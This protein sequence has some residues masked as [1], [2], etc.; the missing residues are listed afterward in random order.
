M[1]LIFERNDG[2]HIELTR[3]HGAELPLSELEPLT[4]FETSALQ[5]ILTRTQASVAVYATR[6]W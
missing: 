4:A 5:G 2:S 1:K 6:W 3:P